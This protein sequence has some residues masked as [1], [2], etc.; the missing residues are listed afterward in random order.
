MPILTVFSVVLSFNCS[1]AGV[2]NPQAADRCWSTACWEPGRTGGERQVSERNF[3]CRSPSLSLVHI[4][5]WTFPPAH[6]E[7]LSSKKPVPSAKKV[8]DHC[9]RGRLPIFQSSQILFVINISLM[10]AKFSFKLDDIS[11]N[12]SHSMVIMP[13]L[14]LLT[15]RFISLH[16]VCQP[17]SSSALFHQSGTQ[18]KE[19]SP[20]W[21]L[22]FMYQKEKRDDRTKWWFTL[23][24]QQW[25]TSLPFTFCWTKA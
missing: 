1:R 17:Q 21:N 18:V 19:S 23:S 9:S 2:P 25:P 14:K 16:V 10:A 15:V 5:A 22:L 3:I 13:K 11:V 20:L 7:K 4:T 12:L 24:A 8:G 6:M